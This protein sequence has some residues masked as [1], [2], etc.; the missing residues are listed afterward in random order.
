MFFTGRQRN[1]M[2]M[3]LFAFI[4]ELLSFWVPRLPLLI[5]VTSTQATDTQINFY[6]IGLSKQQHVTQYHFLLDNKHQIYDKST[7]I[8]YNLYLMICLFINKQS[9]M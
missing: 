1:H 4:Y 8:S 5:L 7:Q 9:S 2:G 6:F 3:G